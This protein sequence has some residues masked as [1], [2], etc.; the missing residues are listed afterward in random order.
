[1][2][3]SK[4][5]AEYG[6]F[7]T[8]ASLAAQVCALLARRGLRPR[9]L[10]E[11]TCGFGSLLFAGIEQFSVDRAVGADINETYIKW[12]KAAL[13]QRADRAKVTLTTADFFAIDWDALIRELPE[14][15]LVLGN[16]PWVTNAHLASLGSQNL[17]VKSNF[18]RQ[19]GMDAITGKANF[20]ISDWMLFRLLD[21]L[22][23]HRGT[24]AMLC[25][26]SVARKALHHAWKSGHAIREFA[27]HVIDA[28]THFDASVDAVLLIAD[29]EPGGRTVEAPIYPN[30]DATTPRAAV[31][32]EGNLLLADIAAFRQWK[33]LAGASPLRWRS[34][35]KHDCS[36]VMELRREATNVRP[37]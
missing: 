8:P 32:F 25:K 18:Q 10:L 36:K 16:P 12:A 35:I 3:K 14:P 34:G 19:S 15:V 6:D 5:K 28:V 21:V 26:S 23:G 27:I 17:P 9:S 31:G 1:M 29:F 7:Q 11:P 24:L 4:T 37:N 2:A 20:D 33:H 13:A 22:D 30:L